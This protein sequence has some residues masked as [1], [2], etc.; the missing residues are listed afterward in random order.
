MVMAAVAVLFSFVGC[1][2][3]STESVAT[4]NST[5]ADAAL[6]A[7]EVELGEAAPAE[8]V[9]RAETTEPVTE[10]PTE[11]S[12][13]T[14]QVAQ[15]DAAPAATEANNEVQANNTAQ[16]DNVAQASAAKPAASAKAGERDWAYWRGP[17]YNGVSYET[18]LPDEFDPEGGEG[19]NVR[20]KR[21][22]VGGRSSPI[23]MNGRLYT[24]T[25]AE[26][27]TPREGEKVV[28]LDAN[29]GET[30]WENRF[31]V[32][33]SDVPAERVGWSSVVGDPETDR[34]Y[35]QGAGGYFQCIDGKTGET[36]WD[37]ALHEFFGLLTT[38]GGRTNF[39]I[40]CD[41]MVIVSGVVIGWGEMARP[42]HRLI[43]FDKATGEVAWYSGT[44]DLPDDTT[45][46]APTMGVVN[47]QKMLVLGAGDGQVWAFQPRTGKPLWHYAMSRRGVNVSPLL[48]DGRVYMTQSEENLVGTAMGAVAAID[49]S[50]TGNV[51]QSGQLWREEEIMIGKSS[52]VLVDGRLYCVDDGAK[53]YVI[54]AETGEVV[55]PRKSLGTVM[56]ASLLA[57]DGK[58]YV[59][60]T[61][62]RWYVLKP[63][64]E[65][66][67]E[68]VSK[69]RFGRNEECHAS[70]IAVNGRVYAVTTGAVY[71]LEDSSKQHGYDEPPA[72]EEETPVS[73]DDQ[74][75]HVQIIPSELLIRPEQPQTFR[76]R[77]YNA[78]G[79]LLREAKPDEVEFSV[80]GPGAVE[81][82]AYQAPADTKHQAAYVTAKVGEL[83][84]EARIRIVPALPW[85]F[86][87]E[88][89]SDLPVTWVG[90][91]YRHVIRPMDGSN[92]AV[93]ISTIPK[94]TRSR[95]WMG[96]TDLHDYTIQAE[97]R[98]AANG[99]Q[100]PDIGL[101]AQGYT[102]D[103]KGDHQRLQIRTWDAQVGSPDR[104][105]RMAKTID[106]AWEPNT[107]YVMKLSV[108]NEGG[109][110][111]VRGKVWPKSE[112]E[113]EAW[114]I[115][116]VDD[117]PNTA[118]APGLFGNATDA[119]IY[120]DNITVTPNAS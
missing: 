20:W 92:V 34:V 63:D 66:G 77:L 99:D 36:V 9:E 82:G 120:L 28:C 69:G 74:V 51:S 107:W 61:N 8:N 14:L 75:A 18:G 41:D 62:G 52:P 105:L 17:H 116:A 16:G 39:P 33:S 50:K 27:A 118:G 102:L 86:D 59:L 98:G 68:I 42:N 5:S 47:G 58:I 100:Q 15:A 81:N 87:F 67:V 29:T 110:A 93:K 10:A 23:V 54:D 113:P 90:A 57:A 106:F 32:W 85:S 56:R 30:L 94:G 65:Q 40:I 95:S 101:I 60:E 44:R 53:L 78:N 11:E 80:E 45:Y 103:M 84:N 104:S 31:N 1:I 49:A 6:P 115:E 96:P 71:C 97:V 38:Y 109:K 70:P 89:L 108:A 48:I 83:S 64:E 91:R 88:G 111:I 55:A 76:V 46:S 19:S 79:Q 2:G 25:E 21:D 22:D 4:T 114:T 117:V 7:V 24:I 3:V 26:H 35:A 12:A 119:E 43:A 73:Q 112:K 13:E 37:I 72:A